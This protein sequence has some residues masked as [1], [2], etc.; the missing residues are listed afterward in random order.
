MGDLVQIA[1]EIKVFG[2]DDVGKMIGIVYAVRESGNFD[3]HEYQVFWQDERENITEE[4]EWCPEM[5]L[6][7]IKI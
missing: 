5:F 6:Q 2:D 4:P 3:M 1:A 7:T